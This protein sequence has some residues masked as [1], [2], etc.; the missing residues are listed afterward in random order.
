MQ[1]GGSQACSF[2][3]DLTLTLDIEVFNRISCGLDIQILIHNWACVALHEYILSCFELSE[4]NVIQLLMRGN[5]LMAAFLFIDIYLL[6][7]SK[8]LSMGRLMCPFWL[9]F[10]LWFFICLHYNFGIIL[11]WFPPLCWFQHKPIFPMVI[12]QYMFLL[13]F[14]L[15]FPLSLCL[16]MCRWKSQITK[17]KGDEEWRIRRS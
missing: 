7:T 17:R 2:K 15:F 14:Y 3:I 9:W 1:I 6:G 8:S 13:G 12:S 10:C 16:C 4:I 11:Y 5:F